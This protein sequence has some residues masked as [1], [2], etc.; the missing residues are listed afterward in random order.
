[1]TIIDDKQ[2]LRDQQKTRLAAIDPAE[3]KEQSLSL[4]R[5]L[6]E[7]LDWQSSDRVAITLSLPLEL[8]TRPIIQQ[9]WEL[10]KHVFVPKIVDK[11]MIFVEF[12]ETTKIIK[13]KMSISEPEGAA[14]FPKNDI[15]LMIVP[16]LAFTK[17]GKRL[18]FGAGYYDRYLSDYSGKTL[19]LA[20]NDQLLAAIPTDKLDVRVQQVLA[21]EN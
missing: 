12:T 8:S 15:D 21:P 14:A 3:K 2:A 7:N 19:S 5:Q 4:Y 16:G 17:T 10:D 1:M 13:G 9:A 18:G 11:K 6:F 20:L